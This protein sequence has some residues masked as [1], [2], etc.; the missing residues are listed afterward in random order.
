MPS[1]KLISKKS[2]PPPPQGLSIIKVFLFSL[3]PPFVR[4]GRTEAPVDEY[5]QAE[6]VGVS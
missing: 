5:N 3:R 4:T 6:T 1:F 2:P